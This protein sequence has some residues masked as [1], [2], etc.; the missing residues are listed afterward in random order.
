MIA[1][2]KPVGDQSQRIVVVL[3]L[4]MK[5]LPAWVEGRK[6]V[7]SSAAVLPVFGSKYSL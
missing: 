7:V 6:P 2:G 3:E 1:T 4:G 5:Q